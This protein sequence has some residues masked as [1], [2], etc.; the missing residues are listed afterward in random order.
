MICWNVSMK[1]GDRKRTVPP[2]CRDW[3]ATAR[4]RMARFYAIAATISPTTEEDHIMSRLPATT[5]FA[6]GCLF[7][8]APP[9]AVAQDWP[10]KPIRFISPFPPGGSVDAVARVFANALSPILGQPIVV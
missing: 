1:S 10:S 7:A 8:L 9:G 2:L 6:I 4:S 5:A 3:L